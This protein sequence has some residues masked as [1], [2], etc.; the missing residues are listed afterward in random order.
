VLVCGLALA[1]ALP[2]AFLAVLV[3][4]MTVTTAYS[5]RL[6]HMPLVDV[7]VLAMLYTGRVI[8]GAAATRV[9]PSPWLLGFSLFFFLSLAFVK[10]YSELYG[11]R[12][13]RSS[14]KVRG[15]YPG[16]L[17]MIAINGAVSGYLPGP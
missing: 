1:V 10:R 3:I 13:D 16:D 14:L 7:L 17:E 2:P 15:Y 6:K 8:A 9:W 11:L 4:Y 5:F 12:K